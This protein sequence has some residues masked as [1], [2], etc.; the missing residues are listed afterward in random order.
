MTAQGGTSMLSGNVNGARLSPLRGQWIEELE[1]RQLLS[2][3]PIELRGAAAP[4]L[5]RT[6]PAHHSHHVHH[7]RHLRSVLRAAAAAR[8]SV[9][10]DRA[11]YRPGQNA[12]I[13]G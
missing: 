6:H 7:V 11:D 3:A 10:T 12:L 13:T 8:A 4:R 9:S 5:G 2:V 1:E